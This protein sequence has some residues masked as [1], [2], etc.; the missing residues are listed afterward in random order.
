MII[1]LFLTVLIIVYGIFEYR[2]YRKHRD[3]IKYRIHVNGIRGKSS[4]TRLIAS[5]LRESGI[6]TIGKTTGSAPRI[7]DF[8]GN[9]NDIR[10]MGPARIIEQK[11]MIDKAYKKRADAIVFECMAINPEMQFC[12]E[13]KLIRSN[14]FVL[15]N[16]RRDHLDV[17]G[18]TEDSIFDS[19]SLS[20]PENSTII[21]S[22]KKYMH[23]IM[24]ICENKN[25]RL[26]TADKS[27]FTKSIVSELSYVEFEENVSCAVEVAKLLN[28][29][30]ETIKRGIFKSTPDV[31]ATT[32]IKK[33]DNLFINGFAA[34]DYESTINLWKR[35]N[36]KIDLSQYSLSV[37]LNN[38]EDRFFRVEEMLKAISD[39]PCEEV[40]LTGSYKLITNKK[41]NENGIKKVHLLKNK[42]TNLM[43]KFE[44]E[45]K[46]VFF[47][48]GN[49]KDAGIKIIDYFIKNGEFI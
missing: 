29:N 32:I 22:E 4:T 17:L 40:F 47:G 18:D 5:I 44:N 28:I 26:I 49:I 34:N 42:D 10:R 15:T 7:I 37:I 13:N 21:T 27:L 33:G 23:Q 39:L 3:S 12:S 9:E 19:L 31:G 38:R 25:N 6:K 11:V 8:N 48:L 16:I 36:E 45:R 41:L 20:F 24:E 14:I 1:I 46:K 30:E 43:T 2:I 35:I